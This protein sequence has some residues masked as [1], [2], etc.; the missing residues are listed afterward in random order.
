M[1]YLSMEAI[2]SQ[3]FKKGYAVE[4]S[5]EVSHLCQ[6]SLELLAKILN[7]N[8]SDLNELEAGL[9]ALFRNREK[10][11]GLLKAF[12]SS[13]EILQ[14][15]TSEAIISACRNI[16][17]KVPTLATTPVLHVVSEDLVIDYDKVFTPPHQDVVSTKGSINQCVV[18]IPL[19]KIN[20]ANYGMFFYEG[21]HRNG[22]LP[23]DYSSF[24]HTVKKEF[25]PANPAIYAEMVQ[26]EFALFSKYLVHYT[27]NQGRFRLAVSFRFNDMEDINWQNRNFFT[28]FTRGYDNSSYE[29][30]R[31]KIDEIS[32]EYFS[33]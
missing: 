28:P 2:Q 7:R 20:Q 12:A 11:I 32:S 19:H 6:N 31:E 3:Y 18:W 15:T 4:Y 21:S 10:Y 25:I 26:G 16:G 14:F 13:T 24:G 30:G 29:D 9:K 1:Y 23:T 17:I 8:S 27:S 5:S 33:Q 22:V